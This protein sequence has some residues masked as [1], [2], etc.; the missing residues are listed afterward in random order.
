[1]AV[2]IGSD[3]VARAAD[4]MA[5]IDTD[6]RR[7]DRSKELENLMV[8]AVLLNSL[9]DQYSRYLPDPVQCG[10]SAHRQGHRNA[11]NQPLT[12][13]IGNA[14]P[15]AIEAAARLRREIRSFFGELPHSMLQI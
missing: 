1:M 4:E 14:K 10:L 13:F 15:F 7:I 3:A 2:R 12:T 6:R 11:R 8:Q 9:R 5:N